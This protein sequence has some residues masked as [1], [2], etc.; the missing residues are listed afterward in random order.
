MTFLRT[1]LVIVVG[2]LLGSLSF[3]IIL[4]RILGRDIRSQGSGNAG[5]TNMARVF[6]WGAGAGTLM[7]DMLKAIVEK[8][9]SVNGFSLPYLADRINK[10]K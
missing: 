4:S 6:G 7:F 2:Y 8:R 1:M 9:T 10:I 5:A 3:S